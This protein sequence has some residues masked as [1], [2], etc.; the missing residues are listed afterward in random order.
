MWSLLKWMD[1]FALDFFPSVEKRK[2][3]TT[4]TVKIIY[5]DTLY[6]SCDGFGMAF[7]SHLIE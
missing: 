7:C 4:S 3:E 1:F 2:L 5:A 6:L